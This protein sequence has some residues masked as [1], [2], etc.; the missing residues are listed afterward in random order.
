MLKIEGCIITDMS[1]PLARALRT[2]SSACVA[3]VGAGGKTSALFQ[4]ARQL[5]APVIVTAT[6]HLGVWQIPFAD[7]HILTDTPAALEE[8][9]HGLQG[10]ILVT[11]SIDEDR[12]RPVNDHLLDWLHQFCGYHAIPLLIEADGA[13][14]KPLKAW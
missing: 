2:H 1:I 11:G 12:T 4:L 14:Q 13:R 10:V 7:Q 8:I 3:F 5:P 6:S 9:E